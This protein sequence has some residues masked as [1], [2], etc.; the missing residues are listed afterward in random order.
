MELE[1]HFADLVEEQGSPGGRLDLADHAGAPGSRERALDVAKQLARENVTR[2]ATAVQRHE[3]AV[4]A[5]PALVN[6]PGKHLLA[7][8]GLALQQ[9]GDIDVRQLP[10]LLGGP[11]QGRA[12]TDD[13]A[14]SL[15][16]LATRLLHRDRRTSDAR[17][18][19][20]LQRVHEDDDRP[21]PFSAAN[22]RF[23]PLGAQP[24]RQRRPAGTQRG[25]SVERVDSL[26]LSR[27]E[28]D[29]HGRQG[30]IAGRVDLDEAALT[31]EEDQT[32]RRRLRETSQARL[33]Q[34]VLES[35]LPLAQACLD[36]ASRHHGQGQPLAMERTAQP[37]HVQHAQNLAGNGIADNGRGASPPLDSGAE[38][39]RRVDLHRLV[40]GEGSPNGVRAA[41][42]L[43]PV[44]PAYEA[45][46]LSCV[47]RGRVAFGFEDHPCRIGEDHHGP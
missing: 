24:I 4:L 13:V 23:H 47:Q 34:V 19:S 15:V 12:A 39:L 27:V 18:R 9:H 26:V 29:A 37:G 8:P 7:D 30:A 3:A 10:C 46:V 22:H 17:A 28:L 31:V 38:V 21:H 14:E 6:R 16:R 25:V 35:H 5:V 2:Q 11:S 20:P 42:E 1:R 32:A 44:R 45:D 36:A 41:G 33:Q 43:I 40:D